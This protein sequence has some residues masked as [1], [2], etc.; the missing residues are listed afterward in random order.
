MQDLTV[1]KLG[2]SVIFSENL[3][4]WIAALIKLDAPIV[5]VTGGGDFA[6]AVRDTQIEM[7]L[8]DIAAHHMA[9]LTMDQTAYAVA[10]HDKKLVVAQS[11]DQITSALEANQIPV[12]APFAMTHGNETIEQS[13]D[14]TS[15][16][17]ALWLAQKLTADRLCLIKSVDLEEA[18][19]DAYQLAKDNIIDDAFPAQL[20]NANIPAFLLGPT[21]QDTFSL[22]NAPGKPITLA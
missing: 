5:L 15:D 13:W 21:D 12:W 8:D 1:I 2:G 3:T 17:L 11:E 4:G 7:R 22:N 20:E 16:S 9:L 6:D 10:S 18:E 19:Y 14:I